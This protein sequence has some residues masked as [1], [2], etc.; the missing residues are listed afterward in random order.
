MIVA[1]LV[2]AHGSI[3]QLKNVHE[4]IKYGGVNIYTPI[5]Y[6]AVDYNNNNHESSFIEARHYL[7]RREG[8]LPNYYYTPATPRI[9]LYETFKEQ[10]LLIEE[11]NGKIGF[12]D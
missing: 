7:F 8:G 5:S 4:N 9:Q 12:N 1:S 11:K 6:F 3:E 10:I 2:T